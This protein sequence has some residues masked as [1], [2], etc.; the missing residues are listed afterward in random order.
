MDSNSDTGPTGQLSS[1]P[2]S[3]T[4]YNQEATDVGPGPTAPRSVVTASSTVTWTSSPHLDSQS[5]DNLRQASVALD[6]AYERINSL[7]NSINNMLNRIPPEATGT[8]TS[9]TTSTDTTSTQSHHSLS[10]DANIRPPHS[11]LVLS[12]ERAVEEL[13]TRAARLR[14]LVS[15]SARQRLE[16]FESNN[17]NNARREPVWDRFSHSN[18]PRL[19]RSDLHP[20]LP[21][22]RSPAIPD[23]VLPL[24]SARDLID[25]VDPRAAQRRDLQSAHHDDSSTMIGRRV[26]A[27][28][29]AP[30]SP[31]SLSSRLSLSQIEQRL[32]AQTAQVARELENMT[33]RLAASRSRRVELATPRVR[34]DSAVPA[35][36]DNGTSQAGSTT[37]SGGVR[38]L[39]PNPPVG[40]RP[41]RRTRDVTLVDTARIVLPQ[42]ILRTSSDGTPIEELSAPGR[43]SLSAAFREH[44]A[45]HRDHPQVVHTSQDTP[46]NLANAPD[47]RG[48]LVNLLTRERDDQF[49]PGRHVEYTWSGVET[50]RR[51]DASIR[52]NPSSLAGQGRRRRGWTRLNADGDEIDSDED[53]NVS[54]HTRRLRMRFSYGTPNVDQPTT[55]SHTVTIE[56]ILWRTSGSDSEVDALSPDA[57]EGRQSPFR[58]PPRSPYHHPYPLP[59]PA[60]DMLAYPAAKPPQRPQLICVSKYASLA[61]R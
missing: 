7:R 6:T 51:D 20:T 19:D 12:G 24:P 25:S 39:V 52:S 4:A 45:S 8:G 15:P 61:G 49:P 38:S 17:G 47:V 31:G 9:P 53:D 33:E 23:R 42:Q 57:T 44:I 37:A 40:G 21:P 26:A 46:R 60:E 41:L 13:N 14:S 3:V 35:A 29:N 55:R 43:R 48:T 1:E 28:V 34:G 16:E 56:D 2:I 18:H 30:D 36:Q 27:R 10:H 5:R 58:S 32:Q 59:T 54:P 22:L 11:A 50:N